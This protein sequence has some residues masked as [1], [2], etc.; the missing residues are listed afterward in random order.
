[1]NMVTFNVL[2]GIWINKSSRFGN[3]SLEFGEKV[4]R[5]EEVHVYTEGS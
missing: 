3:G 4:V 2:H 1:M 5:D